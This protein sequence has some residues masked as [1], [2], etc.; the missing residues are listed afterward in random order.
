MNS[1]THL[2]HYTQVK[3]KQTTNSYSQ[4]AGHEYM[5]QQVKPMAIKPQNKIRVL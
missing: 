2:E 4:A 5:T 1:Q 3:L